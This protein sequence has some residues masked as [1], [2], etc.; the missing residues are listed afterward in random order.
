[1]GA[2]IRVDGDEGAGLAVVTRERAELAVGVVAAEG[3]E[4][5]L[6]GGGE[7]VE[8]VLG[9]GLSFLASLIRKGARGG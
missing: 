3:E 6:V 2:R 1:M 5:G 4:G 8:L 9:L 7:G